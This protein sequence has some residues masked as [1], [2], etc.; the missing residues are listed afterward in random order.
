VIS[1]RSQQVED[2]ADAEGDICTKTRGEKKIGS[3]LLNK[4]FIKVC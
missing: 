4:I 1:G 2:D 3:I